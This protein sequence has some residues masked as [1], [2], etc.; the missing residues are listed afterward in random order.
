MVTVFA[1]TSVLALVLAAT[2]SPLS[3][4]SA[5]SQVTFSVGDLSCVNTT[6]RVNLSSV[7]VTLLYLNTSDSLLNGTNDS[8]TGSYSWNAGAN[9]TEDTGLSGTVSILLDASP[10]TQCPWAGN[11]WLNWTD[12]GDGSGVDVSI[13]FAPGTSG[14]SNGSLTAGN[15]TLT[16]SPPAPAFPYFLEITGLGLFC[17]FLYWTLKGWRKLS[18][19]VTGDVS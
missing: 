8:S 10:P 9:Y 12:V 4:P 7:S 14:A 19:L 17:I 1:V 2:P 11:A 6:S 16:I 13:T 5:S 3:V 15:S 18:S